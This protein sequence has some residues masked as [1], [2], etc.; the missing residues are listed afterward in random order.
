MMA[1]H[2]KDMTSGDY[3]FITV[4]LLPSENLY[5]LWETGHPDDIEAR[6]AFQPLIQVQ[7]NVH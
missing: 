2:A 5:T 3:V 7:Y 1:A 4:N 6:Q